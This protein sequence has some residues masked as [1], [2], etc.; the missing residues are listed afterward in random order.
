MAERELLE[1]RM[2]GEFSLSYNGKTINDQSSRSKKLWVLLEYLIT[3]RNKEI[4][5]NDLIELL[6]ADDE[7]AN[8]VNTLKTL[9]HRAR[10]AISDLGFS[11][12]KELVVSRRGTY[13]WNNYIPIEVDAD[14]FDAHCK[15]AAAC[16]DSE[17]RLEH[18]LS[19]LS[20]YHGNFLP[21]SSCEA[22]VV[23]ISAYYQSLF[24]KAVQDATELLDLNGRYEDIIAICQKAI[25]IDPYNETFHQSMILALIKN[26]NH[27]GAIHHYDYVTELFF[28]EFGVTPSKELTALYREIV[29]TENSLEL[30]LGTIKQNL[31]D[32][33][34]EP[35][36]FYCEYEFFKDI[37]KLNARTCAR[38]GQ[39]IQLALLTL[40]TK[41]GDQLVKERVNSNMER[42]REIVNNSLRRGDIYTRY[43]I[44]QYLL[45]L[46]TASFENSEMVVNRIVRSY[47]RQYPKADVSIRYKLLPL[48]PE[49]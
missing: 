2:L 20:V 35:G 47:R 11:G 18:L 8:P 15:R 40:F 44:S 33:V 30:D 6:W 27:K 3:F 10:A 21:K 37:Y 14:V 26:G 1:I 43:S 25:A 34:H 45:M 23:P 12:G 39:V 5:Q 22:W 31:A 38:S 16:H 48:D 29:K 36:A 9:L 32:A 46:P 28:N 42:L 4:S 49:F 7:I 13:A 19:A 17:E 24:I 41:E